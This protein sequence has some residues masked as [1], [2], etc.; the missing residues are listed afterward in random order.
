MSDSSSSDD[1]RDLDPAALERRQRALQ[2]LAKA[3][4]KPANEASPKDDNVTEDTDGET[5]FL[6]SLLSMPVKEMAR[7]VR[8]RLSVLSVTR[9]GVQVSS[10]ATA[11]PQKGVGHPGQAQGEEGEEEAETEEAQ[12]DKARL[13]ELLRRLSDGDVSAVSSTILTAEYWS[14][15]VRGRLGKEAIEFLLDEDDSKDDVPRETA[16]SSPRSHSTPSTVASACAAGAA[17]GLAGAALALS[18]RRSTATCAVVAAAAAAASSVAASRIRVHQARARPKELGIPAAELDAMRSA[19]DA[20]GYGSVCPTSATWNWDELEA[21]LAALA[22]AA[23]ALRDAGW[24]PAFVFVLPGAWKVIDRLFAPM[25]ALLGR[26]CM[27]DPSVFCWIARTP[28]SP[29]AVPAPPDDAPAPPAGTK[30]AAGSNFGLPHRDFTCLQSLRKSDGVPNVLSVWLPL[31]RVTAENGCMMV[32]PRQLDRHFTKRWAYAHM[33]PALPPDEDDEA[34]GATEIR[35]DLAGARPLAPLP[36]GSLVAWVGNLIHWG[37][38]C[39]PDADAPPR[40]SVGFNFLRAGERLQ[41]GAPALDR[42][43]ARRLGL[44]ERLSLIAR[45]VLAYSPWYTLADDAVPRAFFP[46]GA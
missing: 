13:P 35:F 42:E 23:D 29:P 11:A 22:A 3:L 6:R 19:L 27:M 16:S 37:T 28:S 1:E 39:M 44:P 15:L 41:S 43:A 46:P 25:E 33:R 36:A 7:C 2:L 21:L 9:G 10:V 18:T 45:S 30:P 34:D 17:A 8:D 5:R 32:V 24:P 20:R 40:I 12:H 31:R 26:D 38:C 4:N 14:S